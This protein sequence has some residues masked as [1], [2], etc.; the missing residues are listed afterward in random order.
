[1]VC[2]HKP[3]LR[4]G[5]DPGIA[6]PSNGGPTPDTLGD[7]FGQRTFSGGT[8]HAGGVDFHRGVDLLDNQ[9]GG[10]ETAGKGGMPVY[11][12]ING[13]VIRLFRGFFQ[14]DDAD[15]ISKC[16]EVDA[17][18]KA[19][20]ARSGSALV[21]TGK[22]NGTVTFPSGLAM[23]QK[24]EPFN[25]DLTGNDWV[26]D[27]QL[28]STI[29]GISGK[30][31]MGI[32]DSANNEYVCLE[33]NGATYTCK[34]RKSSGTMTNDGATASQSGKLWGRIYFQQSSGK[35][36]WQ[37]STDGDTWTDIVSGGEAWTITNR[38]G[39]MAFI[40]WDPAASGAD[41]TV[42]VEQ[43]GSGD[44]GSVNRFG[45][46]I[47][48]ADG[49]TKFALLHFRRFVVAPG[50]VV[51]AGQLI[52]YTGK[53]GWDIRSGR[54]LQNHV[55]VE[56]HANNQHDYSN[57]DPTNPLAAALLPRP[58]T[59]VSIS[60][61][62]DTASDPNTGLIP[63]HRLTITVTRGSNQNF[64]INEFRMVANLATRT[65]NWNT[66]AGLD[67]ADNDANVYDGLYFQ[68][69]AF[70]ETSSAYVFKLYASQAVIGITW[71]SGYV[72]DADGNTVWSG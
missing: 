37:W 63:C 36:F 52:G 26:M 40:G 43:W 30:L 19:T 16:T 3:A 13:C 5:S 39:F 27:F 35:I 57:A 42:N 12:P 14:F 46:W 41:D 44:G 2:V 7:M 9:D 56:Y 1:M 17:S 25:A 62:R 29:A 70:D 28:V 34:G 8:G 11:S 15:D 22:N 71:T 24:T 20:F 72:K 60:V 58:S 67:P 59:A 6:W 54:I 4:R 61:V 53:T 18:S 45:N 21:I 48:I 32:Y 69:V 31:V 10:G 51:R 47:E 49:S 38:G 33:Y 55:H 68:P 50:D 66:R 23:L 64:Q 65:L